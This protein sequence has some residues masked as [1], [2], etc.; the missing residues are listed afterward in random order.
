MIFRIDNPGKGNQTK[1][2]MKNNVEVDSSN[3]MD[4]NYLSICAL[5]L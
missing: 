5:D 3:I 4:Q 2:V 1:S